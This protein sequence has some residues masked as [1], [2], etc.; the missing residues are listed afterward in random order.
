MTQNGFSLVELMIVLVITGILLSFTYPSY[1]AYLVRTHRIEGQTALF[2]LA[3]RMEEYFIEHSDYSLATIG[4]NPEQ[5]VLTSAITAQGWYELSIVQ[6][7]NEHYLLQ[8]TPLGPQGAQD[9]LCQSLRLNDQGIESISPGPS[10]TPTGQ[11]SE[12]WS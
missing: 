2:D 7:S 9:H 6:S 8:A 10:G 11:A 5:D 4:N 1:Q 12:C 3:H